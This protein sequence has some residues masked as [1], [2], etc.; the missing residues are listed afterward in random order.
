MLRRCLQQ[1]TSSRHEPCIPRGSN[2]VSQLIG[3]YRIKNYVFLHMDMRILSDLM[4]KIN[5]EVINN[6]ENNLFLSAKNLF[7]GIS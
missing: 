6:R 7:L 5:K 3:F 4:S 1:P 2:W